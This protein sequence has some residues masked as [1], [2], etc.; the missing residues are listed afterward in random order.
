M[1]LHKTKNITTLLKV[2]FVS[3]N[4]TGNTNEA[5]KTAHGV[6][7]ANSKDNASTLPNV[8]N[9]SD[10][11][12]YSFFANQRFLKKTGRNLGVNWTDTIGFDK[13]KVECYNCHRRGH[14]ARECM[15]PKHQDYK[16]RETTRR[17][18][19]ERPTNFALMAY[20]S[21]DFSSSS[22]SDSEVNDKYNIGKGDHAVPY[23]Y[24]MNFMP[25]KPD[26][27]LADMDEYVFSESVTSV[28]DII[29]DSKDENETEPK[30]KQR[31]SS[32]AKVEFVKSNEHV[33]SPRESVK[34][35][36]NNKQAKYPRKNSQSPR[37]N[38]RNWDNLMT[39]KL[40]RNGYMT[41]KDKNEAKT[42]KRAWE[43][44]EHKNLDHE[45][46][47][48]KG[49]I[50]SG[51]FRHMTGNRSYFINYEEI[52]G[53]FVAFGGSTKG[54]KITWNGL[55]RKPALSFMIPFGCTVTILNTI[56]HL[57]PPFSSSF[58][59]SPDAGFKP[60]GE[61]E[62]KN[63]EDDAGKKVTEIPK[64]ESGISNKEDDKDD[65][66]LRDEFEKDNV[67]DEYI[68]Y[69]CADD[70]NMPNLE[71][72]VYS[73]DDEGVGVEAD[74]TNLDTHI[75]INPIP[76]TRIYK[77]NPVKQIIGDIHSPP[78]TRRMT[79]S[80]TDHIE[81]KKTLVDLPYD[82]RAIRT[83]WVY[84]N[85]KVERGIVVRNKAIGDIILVQV[86]V[87]D[88]IFGS[89]R[90]EMCTEFEKMMHKKFRMSSMGEL[91]FFLG[92]QVTQ[93][94][95]GI[96]ISQDKYVDEILKKF[97]FSIVEADSKST[98]GGDFKAI[99]LCDAGKLKMLMFTYI[100]Q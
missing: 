80:V 39:Q 55:S 12:I 38:Q 76:I 32:F 1:E 7:A 17:T 14:F 96:F 69:G 9:L 50:N 31:K 87:D 85:K 37:V 60:S 77:D 24:T 36:E 44:K 95:D 63:T 53:G 73:D 59:N 62:K 41:K 99:A 82:K 28:P 20:T 56:D 11:V 25:P 81:P 61:E 94:D 74:M 19:E 45:E 4:I 15:A 98:H 92:L 54:G 18:A 34:K 66:D 84:K 8:D 64:K 51:C 21:S 33:K 71:E 48:D 89:T 5:V 100:D 13:T 6:S 75:I 30:S 79:K 27:V 52:N 42:T 23:P 47:K 88:I 57:D 46:L 65:Q 16:N 10:A 29:S 43:W 22:S 3:S 49:V 86:Y 78:Q 58:K 97:S 90:K 68:V 91:T 2:A 93:K 70:P 72:I 26:L 35:V 83:K 67:A 40:E